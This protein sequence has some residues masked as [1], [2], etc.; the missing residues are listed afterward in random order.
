MKTKIY[1]RILRKLWMNF[2]GKKKPEAVKVVELF[3]RC[4]YRGTQVERTDKQDYRRKTADIETSRM[5]CS[6]PP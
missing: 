1:N 4:F 5:Q 2:Q 3:M 6:H